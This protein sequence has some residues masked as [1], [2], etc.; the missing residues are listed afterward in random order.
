MLSIINQ[1]T[2]INASQKPDIKVFND[3]FSIKVSDV[4]SSWVYSEISAILQINGD[5]HTVNSA[6]GNNVNN[7]SIN[8]TFVSRDS[9]FFSDIIGKY[10]PD[11]IGHNIIKVGSIFTPP[12][13]SEGGGGGGTPTGAEAQSWSDG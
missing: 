3:R 2:R 8:T 4:N 10:T 6:G 7:A 9:D 11:V 12:D 5:S 13:I 1:L